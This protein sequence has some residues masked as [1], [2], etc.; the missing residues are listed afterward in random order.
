MG[1]IMTK[2]LTE[3]EFNELINE[4]KTGK[5]PSHDEIE[6]MRDYYLN[7]PNTDQRVKEG[8]IA[9][10]NIESTFDLIREKNEDYG[11]HP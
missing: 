10:R 9:V 3:D 11:K 4:Y 7:D 5:K 6:K 1:E 2:L 8:I